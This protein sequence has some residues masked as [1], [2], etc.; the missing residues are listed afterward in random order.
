M[1]LIALAALCVLSVPLTGGHLSRLAE[2]RLR[3]AWTPIAALALQVLIIT[4]APEGNPGLHKAVHIGTYVM[5]GLFLF[6]NRRLPG[7]AVV[8]LGALSNALVIVLNDGQMP[9]STTAQ[10]LAGL[11]SGPGFQNSAALAHPALPWLGDVIPWPGPLHNVLSA[12]DC[13]IY[14]GML[15]VVHRLARRPA[16]SGPGGESRT[17]AASGQRGVPEPLAQLGD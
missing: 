10:R 6:L 8:G 2:V 16:P 5:L 7:M 11:H 9:A 15:V 13:L 3:G 17:V 12:G 1:I 4:V 14:L